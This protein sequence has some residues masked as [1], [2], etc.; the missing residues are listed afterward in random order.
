MPRNLII[1]L[2]TDVAEAWIEALVARYQEAG[3]AT[4]I[5]RVTEFGDMPQ[6]FDEP[7]YEPDETDKDY[8][9][10]AIQES[11]GIDTGEVVAFLYNGYHERD[12][13][14][15]D[16][17]YRHGASEQEMA[18]VFFEEAKCKPVYTLRNRRTDEIEFFERHGDYTGYPFTV[19]PF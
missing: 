11:L 19:D 13:K 8:C 4:Q 6:R 10:R 15:C 16:A 3:I 18:R 7:H 1:I 2:G 5:H 9:A 12:C 14:C 17:E